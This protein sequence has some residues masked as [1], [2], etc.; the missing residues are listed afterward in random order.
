LVRRTKDDNTPRS[1]GEERVPLTQ[2]PRGATARVICAEGL[3]PCDEFLL[4]TLGLAPDTCVR[5][6]RA[7]GS[8][9]LEVGADS[10]HPSRIAL[11]KSIADKVMVGRI[12]APEGPGRAGA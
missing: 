9:I 6:C 5:V 4:E 12:D 2:L 10:A 1:L 11:A 7:S 3:A 8:C